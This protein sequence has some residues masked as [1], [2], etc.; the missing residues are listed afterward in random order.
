MMDGWVREGG[1]G[2][3]TRADA[4]GGNR[5]K[6]KKEE[7]NEGWFVTGA[8]MGDR[9]KREGRDDAGCC[10]GMNLTRLGGRPG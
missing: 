2:E 1:K 6:K 5:T 8:Q 10:F 3:R 9:L 4:M 7:R